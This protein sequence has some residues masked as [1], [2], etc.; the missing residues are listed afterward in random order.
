MLHDLTERDRMSLSF[1]RRDRDG[2]VH[3]YFIPFD[4]LLLIAA[5]GVLIGSALP[6]IFAFRD[7]VRLEPVGV[8]SAIVA[9]LA[10]GFGLFATAK[11][12]VIRSGTL[13]SFGC[14]LMT[15]PMRR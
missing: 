8:A 9:A 5:L 2:I 14:A 11:C 12:S 4:P 3:Q 1:R 6:L 7:L 13:V 15:R 10:L